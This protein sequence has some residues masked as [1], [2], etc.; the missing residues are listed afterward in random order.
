MEAA[1]LVKITAVVVMCFLAGL[2]LISCEQG[3]PLSQMG[4]AK[5]VGSDKCAECHSRIAVTFRNTL[6][7]KVMQDAKKSPRAIQGN[8]ADKPPLVDF[9]RADVVLTH[10][11]QWKQ[12]YIDSQWRIRRAQ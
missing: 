10:G 12:R 9:A 8:F 3:V 2:F 4:P 1:R 7:S 11:I 5:Y 6:H